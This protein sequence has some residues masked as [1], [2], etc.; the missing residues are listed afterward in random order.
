ML[1]NLLLFAISAAS[2]SSE[3]GWSTRERFMGLRFEFSSADA[4]DAAILDGRPHPVL[5]DIVALAD[6][7]FAFGWVQVR[8]STVA[9]PRPPALVFFAACAVNL[10]CG[11]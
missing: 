6:K 11:A 7:L 8:P 5:D 3:F 1:L 9:L 10:F 2:V 4:V